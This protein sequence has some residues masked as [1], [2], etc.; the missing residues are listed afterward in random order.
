[1]SLAARGSRNLDD[2]IKLIDDAD[3]EAQLRSQARWVYIQTFLAAGALTLL[4]LS[5]PARS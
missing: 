1:M 4:Y 3:V 2:G 5:I